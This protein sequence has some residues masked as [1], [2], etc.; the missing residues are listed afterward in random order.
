[1]G[2]DI[3]SDV[4]FVAKEGTERSDDVEHNMAFPRRHYVTK[5]DPCRAGTVCPGLFE[6]GV[7]FGSLRN[8]TCGVK[9]Q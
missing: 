3:D 7:G 1:M 8:Q 2:Y 9:C 6:R 4:I 5:Y